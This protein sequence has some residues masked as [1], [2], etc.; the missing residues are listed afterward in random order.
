MFTF[1]V[2]FRST[3]HIYRLSAIVLVHIHGLNNYVQKLYFVREMVQNSRNKSIQLLRVAICAHHVSQTTSYPE[4]TL[5]LTKMADVSPLRK[6]SEPSNWELFFG[7]A[8]DV[9]DECEPLR[10]TSDPDCREEVPIRLEYVIQVLQT[11]LPFLS[12]TR[13]IIE[14]IVRNFHQFH[15]QWIGSS[16]PGAPI[17]LCI[18]LSVQQ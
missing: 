12:E 1:K 5:L 16:V 9:F 14:E 15:R 6:R 8:V 7:A 4:P 3:V 2:D 17:S 18:R 10:Q 11:I 13:M